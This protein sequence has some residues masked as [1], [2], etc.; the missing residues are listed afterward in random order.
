MRHLA[1]VMTHH[2][3]RCG[4]KA[5]AS[6]VF[7]CAAMHRCGSR[8]QLNTHLTAPW[9]RGH[10]AMASSQSHQLK[11]V[12]YSAAGNLY[13][14]PWEIHRFFMVVLSCNCQPWCVLSAMTCSAMRSNQHP[15]TVQDGSMQASLLTVGTESLQVFFGWP[16]RILCFISN[17][18]TD[19]WDGRCRR[20]RVISIFAKHI[21][22]NCLKPQYR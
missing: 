20:L 5:K 6:C 8:N 2:W 1:E 15:S 11:F 4:A 18:S 7:L 13:G 3:R 10:E 22:F 17:I 12:F 14:N 21:E 9:P 16:N 19:W